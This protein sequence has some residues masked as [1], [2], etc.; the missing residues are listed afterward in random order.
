MNEIKTVLDAIASAGAYP[1]RLDGVAVESVRTSEG[2]AMV[3]LTGA[4]IPAG[5]YTIAKFEV[6]IPATAAHS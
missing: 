6:L 5:T 2:Q 3:D 1:F 4:D